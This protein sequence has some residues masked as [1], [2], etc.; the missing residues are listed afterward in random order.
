MHIREAMLD[1]AES[2]CC[3]L[4]R[5]IVELCQADHGGDA[6]TIDTWLV[7]KT[8]EN[9]RAWIASPGGHVFVACVEGSIA[10]VGAVTTAGNVTLN[11]VAPEHRFRGVSKA[12]LTRLEEEAKRLG[13]TICTLHSTKTA[14]SFYRSA[15]YVEAGSPDP[16]QQGIAGYPM[17]KRLD[18]GE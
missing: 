17:T 12:I 15:G 13:A 8:P 5:S 4:R 9:V 6:K 14:R 7:N 3:V 1:D 11:Y 2:A 10:G 16:R 18:I